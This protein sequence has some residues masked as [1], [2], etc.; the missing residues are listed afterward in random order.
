MDEGGPRRRG[1]GALALGGNCRGAWP[2]GMASADLLVRGYDRM[3]RIVA[4]A[5]RGAAVLQGPA[6]AALALAAITLQEPAPLG[7][8]RIRGLQRRL[9]GTTGRAMQ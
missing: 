1:A 4:R 6:G 7:D 8:R 3:Q 5:L 2:G 9:P